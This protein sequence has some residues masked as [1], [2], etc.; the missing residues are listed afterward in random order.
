MEFS[1]K[2]IFHWKVISSVLMLVLLVLVGRNVYK[3][4]QHKQWIANL[5]S[6]ASDNV[7]ILPDTIIVDYIGEGEIGRKRSLAIYLPDN[8]NTNDSVHYPVIYFMDG[9]SQFDQKIQEGTEWQV[10]E[11]IDSISALGG[12]SSIVVG[13][14]NHPTDRLTE[15]KPFPSKQIRNETTV[16]GPQHA[17]W[18]ATDVKGW[19]DANYR[20][21]PDPDNTTIG[22]CSLGGLMSWYMITHF[23]EVY[24]NA[25]V[26]SPSLWVGDEVYTWQDKLE[27]WSNKKIYLCAGTIEAPVLEWAEKLHGLLLEKGMTGD[28]LRL[29]PIQDEG[30]WHMCWRKAFKKAYPWIVEN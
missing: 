29:D 13:V 20:T 1:I 12:P 3:D 10:D 4:Y 23:P 18:L 17:E 16:T 8:Y 30:H 28:N 26:F 27:G 15:Y 11:V 24:G 14:Y 2:K 7:T 19:V 21:L 25:L 5:E 9:D 22:G 6:T